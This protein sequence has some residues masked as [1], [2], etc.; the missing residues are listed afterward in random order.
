MRSFPIVAHSQ[1]LKEEVAHTCVS[2]PT[3]VRRVVPSVNQVSQPG[4]GGSQN[5]RLLFMAAWIVPISQTSPS[6][7][8]IS[9]VLGSQAKASKGQPQLCG[10]SPNRCRLVEAL[11]PLRCPDWRAL[12]LAPGHLCRKP[13]FPEIDTFTYHLYRLCLYPVIPV[14]SFTS[15]FSLI[16]GHIF[17]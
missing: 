13:G 14:Q 12:L 17:T 4:P 6:P 5:P 7:S 8:N 1:D 11:S 10:P 9:L 2:R 3:G 15:Y 16:M